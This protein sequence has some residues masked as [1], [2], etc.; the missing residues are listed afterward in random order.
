MLAQHAVG[1]IKLQ[2]V[3]HNSSRF[4]L[5]QRVNNK[6]GREVEWILSA[7][8]IA[9]RSIHPNKCHFHLVMCDTMVRC[10]NLPDDLSFS[11]AC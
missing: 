4:V 7:S 10:I 8:R 3:H 11:C 2:H 6:S 1:T 5:D 9:L